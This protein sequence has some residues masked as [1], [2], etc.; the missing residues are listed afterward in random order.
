M[1]ENGRWGKWG[2]FLQEAGGER[3]KASSCTGADL[4]F[5]RCASLRGLEVARS[6]MHALQRQD[7]RADAPGQPVPASRPRHAQRRP[8]L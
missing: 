4:P 7:G 5:Q 6:V 3:E 8:A 1:G 2:N